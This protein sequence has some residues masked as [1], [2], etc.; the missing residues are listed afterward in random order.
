MYV[1]V[2]YFGVI[3]IENDQLVPL[4]FAERG[5]VLSF[6]SYAT[7]SY[8]WGNDEGHR[9]QMT[10]TANIQSRRKSGGLASIIP[11]LPK[12]LREAI[13]LVHAL[14]IRYIWI[15]AL[16]IV[17]DSSHSW[18]LNARAMHLIYGNAIFTL[19]AADGSDARSGLLALDETHQH[20]QHVE[21]RAHGL[22]LLL[23]QSPEAKI[24]ASVWNKRA[25]TFQERL[26]SKRC[27]IFTGGCVYFQCRSTT[28]SEDIFADRNGR[29]WSLDLLQSPLQMLS[30]LKIRALWFYTQCVPLYTR[31]QLYEPFDILAAEGGMCKLMEYTMQAP[32][33]F[34]LPSSHFDLALLWHPTGPT[35]R[36]DRPRHSKEPKY[37][38]MKFPSWSWCGWKTA[39]VEYLTE[40]TGSCL[41][42]VRSWLA[43]HTWID[44][45]IRDGHGT[46][47]RVWDKSLGME[48][49]SV[50]TTWRGYRVP[51]PEEDCGSSDQYWDED[52]YDISRPS[53]LIPRVPIRARSPSPEERRPPRKT[54]NMRLRLN[55]VRSTPQSKHGMPPMPVRRESFRERERE[56]ETGRNLVV[57]GDLRDDRHDEY[58]REPTRNNDQRRTGFHDR[59]RGDR[60][61]EYDPYG[62]S[63]TA[64]RTP[65][66]LFKNFKVDFTL[67][68]P[69]D[70]YNVRRAT[71][72]QGSARGPGTVRGS[73]FPD[74]PF[75]Q[76]F[77]WKASFHLIPATVQSWEQGHGGSDGPGRGQAPEIG[78][79]LQLC[80][81][82][83]RR[84]DKC[85]SIVVDSKWLREKQY[86]MHV[87]DSGITN[88]T[89]VVAGDSRTNGLDTSD[90]S[91]QNAATEFEFLAISEAKAFTKDEFPDWT[92]Y[93]PKERIESEWDLFF[94][95]LVE[96]FPVEG[97]YRRVALGKVFKAAFTLA[98]DQ[99]C[100]IILG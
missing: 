67:T 16:C 12:A 86:P 6:E 79:S 17:Q 38:D 13:Q 21:K 64:S 53:R 52:A 27:L 42:D 74:Q 99:W 84:G 57:V 80:H 45:H 26:L 2:P 75:L 19:C 77:T 54:V 35:F 72:N 7:V 9:Q 8:V 31:R 56:R 82:M 90:N 28:I 10:T 29:G 51:Q 23:H 87:H 14:G 36:L 39:G 73:E 94:V 78:H 89:L 43:A 92:Y 30:Q 22:H 63:L 37:K 44:W 61:D 69:E 5:D 1:M 58:R 24:K 66:S 3:D 100:E 60:S 46:L 49:E 91:A 47:R 98:D 11:E 62:R 96:H 59:P 85:G 25:W 70:P 83:D 34:G 33:I 68:L 15:D 32:F 81:I 65:A 97:F 4:P 48:D 50:N 55:T 20:Q 18:N 40:T 71:E 95:L 76:F 93:I 41:T 88:S